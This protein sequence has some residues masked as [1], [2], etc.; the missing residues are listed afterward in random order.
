MPE[1]DRQPDPARLPPLDYKRY[2]TPAGAKKLG[3]SL[4]VTSGIVV[5]LL[6]GAITFLGNGNLLDG[7]P[8]RWPAV[9]FWIACAVAVAAWA[10]LGRKRAARRPFLAGFLIAVGICSLLEGACFAAA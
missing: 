4:G 6:G 7:R 1:P 3:T 2:E 10:F 8:S 9:A 5:T